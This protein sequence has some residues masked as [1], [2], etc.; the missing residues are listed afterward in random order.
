MFFSFEWMTIH[1]V[2]PL[3]VRV[4][5]ASR[6]AT[7]GPGRGGWRNRGPDRVHHPAI[8]TRQLL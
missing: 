7:I 1:W 2:G 3:G 5:R 4:S 6:R 8:V